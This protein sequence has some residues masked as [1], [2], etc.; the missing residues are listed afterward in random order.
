MLDTEK[1]THLQQYNDKGCVAGLNQPLMFW[2]L[3]E[4]RAIS[5]LIWHLETLRR[6]HL[7]PNNW[8]KSNINKNG[9]V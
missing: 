5:C 9:M 1:I 7:K 4:N 2:T 8:N 6:W 3:I